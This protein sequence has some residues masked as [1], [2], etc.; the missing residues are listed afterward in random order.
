[1]PLK[2]ISIKDALA[3]VGRDHRGVCPHKSFRTEA[4]GHDILYL[5][6]KHDPY[7]GQTN[8]RYRWKIFVDGKPD[9]GGIIS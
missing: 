2:G 8:I 7:Q 9:A 5:I 1:M 3:Y 4:D 6:Y